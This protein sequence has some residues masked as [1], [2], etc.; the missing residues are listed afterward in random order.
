[1]KVVF[2]LLALHS[3]DL[4]HLGIIASRVSMVTL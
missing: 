3:G 1:V 2:A 4:S